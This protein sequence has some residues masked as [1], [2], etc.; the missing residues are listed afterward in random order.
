METTHK[1][2]DDLVAEDYRTAA[3]FQKYGIDFLS[4]SSKTIEEDSKNKNVSV[5]ELY[6]MGKI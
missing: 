2:L 4:E 3:V 6:W 1:Y 5:K